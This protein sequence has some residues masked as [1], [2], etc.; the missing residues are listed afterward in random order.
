MSIL[1]RPGKPGPVHR[2][3]TP[4]PY[5]FEDATHPYRYPKGTLWRCEECGTIWY[6]DGYHMWTKTNFFLRLL[7]RNRI[8]SNDE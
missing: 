8:R 6:V 3:Q 5:D 1:Y 4:N 7:W 2:C